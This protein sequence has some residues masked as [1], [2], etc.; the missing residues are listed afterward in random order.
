MI[1]LTTTHG[2]IYIL[3]GDIRAIRQAVQCTLV[4]CKDQEW[5]V[6][7]TPEQVYKLWKDYFK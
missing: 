5:Y 7:E 3:A 4:V 2:P 1:K 6:N